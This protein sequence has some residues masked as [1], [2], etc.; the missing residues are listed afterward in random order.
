MTLVLPPD[1]A[2]LAAAV[3]N[4][5]RDVKKRLVHEKH[6]PEEKEVYLREAFICMQQDGKN[7]PPYYP[8]H[9]QI[10]VAPIKRELKLT[11]RSEAYLRAVDEWFSHCA[12]LLSLGQLTE[13]MPPSPVFYLNLKELHA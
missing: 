7:Y 6:W 10:E 13:V 2:Y 1:L 4:F 3:Q 11:P 12:Q 9:E 5:L 8:E